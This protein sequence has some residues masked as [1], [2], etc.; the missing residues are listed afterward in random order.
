MTE[1]TVPGPERRGSIL[2][3]EALPR[4]ESRCCDPTAENRL[5]AALARGLSAEPADT[6]QQV[7]AAVVDFG[8]ADSAGISIPPTN[9]QDWSQGCYWAASAGAMRRDG[10]AAVW[11]VHSI[12]AVALEEGSTILLRRP[13]L[14]FPELA[15]AEPSIVEVLLTPLYLEEQA[16]GVAWAIRHTPDDGLDAE[17]ARVLESLSHFASAAFRHH[18]RE[19]Y[20]ADDR[21]RTRGREPTASMA[22][23]SAE[24][25]WRQ[26]IEALPTPAYATDPEG[27]LTYFNEAAV[28]CWGRKPES[29]TERWCA[30]SNLY[31]PD[32][33]TMPHAECPL[34]T[35]VTE[36][37]PLRGAEV[38][39]ERPDGERRWAEAYPSPLR[40]RDSSLIGGINVLIDTTERKRAEQLVSEQTR[41]LELV[42][43]GA[44][45][46]ECLNSLCA[47]VS[48]IEPSIRAAVSIADDEGARFVDSFAPQFESAF[49]EGFQG[50]LI[51]DGAMGTC[52]EVLAH[53][54]AATSS[55]LPAD[56]QWPQG[57]RDFCAECGVLASHSEPVISTGGR[58]LG[59][60]LLA[61]D[62]PR[63]TSDWER[64]LA[65][66]GAYVASIALEREQSS[67]ILRE[68]KER[69]AAELADMEE[70]HALS[71][72]L[73]R[74]ER[75]DAI[76]HEVLHT[77]AQLLRVNKGSVQI[78]EGRGRPL[79]LVGT[80]GFGQDFIDRFESVDVDEISTC[81]A[82]LRKGERVIVE[83]LSADP[84][85]MELAQVTAPYGVRAALSTPFL[86]SDGHVLGMF[87][88]YFEQAHRP[89]ERELRAL[90]L[91]AQLAARYIE[92][93]QT[94]EAL[95]ESQAHL[96]ELNRSLEHRVHERTDEL[97]RQ[98]DRLRELAIK[99]T[100]AEQRERKRLAAMLHDDL[101]QLVVAARME[102]GWDAKEGDGGMAQGAISRA[103]RL[104]DETMAASRNL[105]RQL[106]PPAL[107]EAGL[108]PALKGLSSDIEGL[109]HLRV[110]FEG[111]EEFPPLS[112]DVKALLFESTRELLINAAKHAGVDQ[113]A[114]TIRYGGNRVRL[115]VSDDGRGFEAE[116]TDEAAGSTDGFGLFSIRERM[117]ALGG[118]I[119]IESAPAEGTLVMLEAPLTTSGNDSAPHPADESSAGNGADAEYDPRIRV[120][121]VDDHA[122][123]REGI[124]RVLDGDERLTVVGE[125][126]DGTRALEMLQQDRADVVL[127]DVNMPR[128]NGAETV[129]KIRRTWPDIVLVGLSVQSDPSTAELMREAGAAGFIPKS[130]DSNQMIATIL[131]LCTP[132]HKRE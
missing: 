75:L 10:G 70:L 127:V 25:H 128:M 118:D 62:H 98:S 40:G 14:D 114:L 100:N 43:S 46:D 21:E 72:R 77:S 88:T 129:R 33:T 130:G 35:A 54:V 50:G 79:K 18:D 124:T 64:R 116:A 56:E 37:R 104:L 131:K 90:D 99:L 57:W 61:F 117:R 119:V 84:G 80:M 95:R 103:Q 6:L 12:N 38:V 13:A 69:L 93:Q 71:L 120:L 8:G 60:F 41:L 52:G 73:M 107:Y 78:R 76:L 51:A 16:V 85:F 31:H 48:E 11:P 32:G 83:D 96:Q 30:S 44:P 92:R 111:D 82:A 91:Y 105:T 115:F 65:R 58:T 101:Q 5:L 26:L 81:A 102:L 68:S 132:E 17:N 24:P 109:Y 7:A 86:G 15:A 97:Q 87:T 121:V 53:G 63:S 125:A 123:V 110:A 28:E 67:R 49:L 27:R 23:E 42:A 1:A 74:Y 106:R 122:V 113:A 89:S 108:V 4:R 20:N 19:F 34:A 22:A 112:D 47:A 29:H 94:E 126:G 36:A 66:F 2:K 39:L 9:A 3:K 55:N 59:S 45:L